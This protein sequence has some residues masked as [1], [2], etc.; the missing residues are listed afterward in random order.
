MW[1]GPLDLEPGEGLVPEP[2]VTA[3]KALA[4]GSVSRSGLKARERRVSEI[5]TSTVP[6]TGFPLASVAFTVF[7]TVESVDRVVAA[8]MTVVLVAR[9]AQVTDTMAAGSPF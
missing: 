5:V 9:Q 3:G 6:E 7:E 1:V 2:L 4:A 8:G